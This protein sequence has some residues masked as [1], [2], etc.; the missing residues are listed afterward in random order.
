MLPLTTNLTGGDLRVRIEKRDNLNRT[1]E[2]CI[3]EIC[4]L[5]QSRIDLDTILTQLTKNEM[6]EV[7]QKLK[8]HLEI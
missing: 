6:N 1:S 7:E 4:T 2:I 3:N 8:K 5:D